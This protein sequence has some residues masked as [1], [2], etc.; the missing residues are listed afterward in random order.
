MKS[1]SKAVSPNYLSG[2]LFASTQ[3]ELMRVSADLCDR[4]FYQTRLVFDEAGMADLTNS[5][6]STGGNVV[7][8]ILRPKL[9]GS[10]YEIIAGERRVRASMA[11]GTPVLALVANYTDHQAAT[12]TL[13]ENVQRDDLNPIEEAQGLQLMVDELKLKQ[14]EIAELVG[15]SRSHVANMLRLLN[16]DLMVKDALIA[17]RIDTGHAK[18]L[19]SLPT[20]SQRDT[21][22]K[23][24]R[25]KWSVRKLEDY[26]R[27]LGQEPLR[28]EPTHHPDKDVANLEAELSEIT[29][30]PIRIITSAN[31]REGE[32][33]IKFWSSDEFE[34]I[35]SLLRRKRK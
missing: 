9:A 28:E 32:M 22:H 23:I 27:K 18:L 11:A 34:Y 14:K 21:L 3:P 25:N 13:I 12:I 24:T 29:G 33:R 16:L 31:G 26:L 6:I 15:K 10:R 4:G 20:Q 17:E 7:P 2:D 30:S 1:P 19:V 8:V 5:I 35:E